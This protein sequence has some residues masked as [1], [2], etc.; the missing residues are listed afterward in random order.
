MKKW[1]PAD[2]PEW[3]DEDFYRTEVMPKLIDVTAQK[4]KTTIDVSF[5]YAIIDSER[6]SDS[7]SKALG[8]FGRANS[9]GLNS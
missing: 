5:P 2:L 4:M 3:L 6:A 9:N 1:N 7:A 8:D